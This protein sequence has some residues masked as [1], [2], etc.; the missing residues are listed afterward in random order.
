MHFLLLLL[1]VSR[2]AHPTLFLSS[3]PF[4]AAAGAVDN[5]QRPF[6]AIVG[7]SK[8]STKIAVIES[9]LNKCD[10]LILG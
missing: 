2:D 3:L 1:C 4:A 6:C 5:P 8:V 9:L 10:K 7:G